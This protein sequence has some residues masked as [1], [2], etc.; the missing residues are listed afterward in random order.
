MQFVYKKKDLF[1]LLEMIFY[2][3]VR[4]YPCIASVVVPVGWLLNF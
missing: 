3:F 1:D 2:P 4:G